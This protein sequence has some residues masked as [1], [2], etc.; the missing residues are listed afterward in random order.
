MVKLLL[1]HERVNPS[2]DNQYALRWACLQE[3]GLD[4][5]R[6]LLADRRIDPSAD[7]QLALTIASTAGNAP[8]TNELLTDPRVQPS[9]NQFKA[10]VK[11]PQSQI[12]FSLLNN[13]YDFTALPRPK[14]E[15]HIL[16]ASLMFLRSSIREAT[17]TESELSQ[18]KVKTQLLLLD[19]EYVEKRRF[20]LLD[21]FLIPD[22]TQL[23]LSYLSSD[24]FCHNLDLVQRS[25]GSLPDSQQDCSPER[26]LIE[27]GENFDPEGDIFA[28]H[29]PFSS[30]S[31]L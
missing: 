22:L 10:I 31:S 28:V 15:N 14:S 2:V 9:V 26:T 21:Q 23:C 11:A 19:I 30:L 25:S 18:A 8:V 7:S 20:G 29:F 5:V 16:V 1:A 12:D 4:V 6:L 17:L 24:F 3:S 13:Q 27:A